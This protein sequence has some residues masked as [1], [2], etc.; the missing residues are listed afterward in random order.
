MKILHPWIKNFSKSVY[1]VFPKIGITLGP[2][3]WEMYIIDV[4]T[5]RMFKSSIVSMCPDLVVYRIGESSLVVS[6]MFFNPTQTE[7]NIDPSDSIVQVNI[8]PVLDTIPEEL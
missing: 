6:L 4:A 2:F 3:E 1:T 8:L 7:K 5:P